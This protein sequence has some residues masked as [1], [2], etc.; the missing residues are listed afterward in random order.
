MWQEAV[1]NGYE[2]AGGALLDRERGFRT[3]GLKEACGDVHASRKETLLI[4]FPH[5]VPQTQHT[6]TSLI[7]LIHLPS[8]CVPSVLFVMFRFLAS[9][10]DRVLCFLCE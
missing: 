10:R 1:H 4:H 9:G 7:S 6:T 2:A 5:P 3:E 8:V